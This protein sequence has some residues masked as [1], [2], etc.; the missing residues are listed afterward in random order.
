MLHA[1][2][3]SCETLKIIVDKLPDEKKIN[4]LCQHQSDIE[5]I[6]N[7]EVLIDFILECSL[8]DGVS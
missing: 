4:F 3:Y 5:N 6:N 2:G 8:R 7:D 1:L